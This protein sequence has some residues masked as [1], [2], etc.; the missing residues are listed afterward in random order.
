MSNIEQI[1]R[2]FLSLKTRNYRLYFIGQGISLCG[3]WMQT[4][5]QAWLVLKITGSGTALGMVGAFQFVPMLVLGSFGGV[6]ADRFSKRNILYFTQT[7]A[8]G[9][10]LML[11]IL[12]ATDLVKLWMIYIFVFSLGLVNAI[13]NPTR[14]TFIMEMVGKDQLPNAVSLN[15][16]EVN[17]A[18]VIG[19]AIG[20][21]L[22]ATLGLAPLFII[23]GISYVGVLVALFRM[24]AEELHPS[25]IAEHTKGQLREGFRY[26]K[27]TPLLLNSL[28]MM[29][30]IGMLSYEFNVSLPLFARFTFQSDAAGYAGL[31][32]A[33]GIG[34]VIGGLYIAT[35]RKVTV[36]M[37]INAAWL[38]GLVI[39]LTAIAP[40][41]WLAMLGMV[42]V[43]I[44][45]INFLSLAHVTL[46]LGSTAQMRG[47]V[48]GLWAVAFLGTTPIGGPIIG[49]I[50]QHAGP[51]WGLAVGGFA[52]LAAG[53]VGARVL[54]KQQYQ[55]IAT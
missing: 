33:M 43:G 29:A 22:I 31:T 8:G 1:G 17:L 47:R 7:A 12:V 26:V 14:Q 39:L 28:L 52:A 45:S 54:R 15:S 53:A 6:I 42:L 44:F 48:M 35:R 37:L 5:G 49:W 50:G 40:T 3:T 32:T 20:G 16:T 4:I 9:L 41:L 27:S 38:F 36:W 25:V 30:I 34:S 51:R 10:A 23:N 19:P 46:Q 55:E 24:R 13:D 2:T 18:R 11:G 21:G